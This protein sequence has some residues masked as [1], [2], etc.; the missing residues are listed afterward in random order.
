MIPVVTAEQMRV[1]D[2]AALAG[3]EDDWVFIRRAGHATA[4]VARTMMGGAYARRVVVIAGKGNNAGHAF[5]VAR[6][7]MALERRVRVFHLD[8]GSQYRGATARNYEILKKMKAK[9]TPIEN[10]G[11]LEDFFRTTNGPFT[12]V[13]GILGTGL[14]GD[15]EGIFYDVVRLINEHVEEIVA[16][17]IPTGVSGDT[18]AIHGAAIQASHTVSFGFPKIWTNSFSEET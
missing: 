3:T 5:V 7:L 6:R 18:G 10:A 4:E 9:L 17:D 11:E 1:A 15:I 8:N 13:D 12:A 16:L 14:K 2:A